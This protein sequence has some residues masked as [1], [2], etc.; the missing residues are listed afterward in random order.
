MS[1]N[2]SEPAEQSHAVVMEGDT[3]ADASTQCSEYCPI[4]RRNIGTQTLKPRPPC[5][6]N[7][8]KLQ[9]LQSLQTV[10]SEQTGHSLPITQLLNDH[11]YSVLIP[12]SP[13]MCSNMQEDNKIEIDTTNSA[14]TITICD[15]H[16]SPCTSE[17][18]SEDE[19]R[20]SSSDESSDDSSEHEINDWK[21]I[22]YE[23]ELDKLFKFCQQCG[24]PI[25]EVTKSNSGSMVTVHTLCLQ[26]HEYTWKSQPTTDKNVPVGNLL[27][28][29]AIVLTGGTFEEFSNFASALKLNFI[30]RSSFYNTQDNI[31]FPLVNKEYK[32]RQLTV[33]NE[34]KNNGAANLCGDGR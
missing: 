6:K 16:T 8:S 7:S 18:D 17:D 31:I 28:P 21:F 22:V 1:E 4:L 34:L 23:C 26:H 33:I 19:Y 25:S 15:N 11:N 13:P 14:D 5:R 2:I 3:K 24:S 32:E 12:P 27:I 10:G 20:C 29:A 9:K 30:G